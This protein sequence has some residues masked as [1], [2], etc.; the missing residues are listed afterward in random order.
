M[1]CRGV[2]H[3]PKI[4]KQEGVCNTPLQ[5]RYSGLQIPKDENPLN[6]ISR[7]EKKKTKNSVYFVTVVTF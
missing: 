6:I 5:V 3:T 4:K 1:Y 2:L 7:E